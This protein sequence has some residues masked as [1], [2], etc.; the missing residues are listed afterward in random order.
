MP[1]VKLDVSF[2]STAT[3]QPG[4]RRTDYWSEQLPGF[5][6][7]TR[8]SGAATFYL[9]YQDAHG[10]QRAFKIGGRAD[11]SYD[12]ARKTAQRLRSEVVLGGDPVVAAI[13]PHHVAALLLEADSPDA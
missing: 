2:C 5:V 10:K 3:C 13:V 7:E 1:K 12:I 4:K 8:S 6:L 11:I 9:R